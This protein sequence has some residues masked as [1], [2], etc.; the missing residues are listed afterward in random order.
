MVQ[1]KSPGFHRG[2]CVEETGPV[3]GLFFAAG[4]HE[5]T[6]NNNVCLYAPTTISDKLA[7]LSELQVRLLRLSY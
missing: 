3:P 2:I 6:I 4:P 5:P 7:P 1:K